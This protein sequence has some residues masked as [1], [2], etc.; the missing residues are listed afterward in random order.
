MHGVHRIH[1][2]DVIS[3]ALFLPE[4]RERTP[5]LLTA[6]ILNAELAGV[7]YKKKDDRCYF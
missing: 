7:I 4:E 2:I 5:T 1:I 6:K 3:L